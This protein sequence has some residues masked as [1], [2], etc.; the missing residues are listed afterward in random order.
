MLNDFHLYLIYLDF[1]FLFLFYIYWENDGMEKHWKNLNEGKKKT[2][3]I[4]AHWKL[5]KQIREWFFWGNLI[6]L[7]WN[8]KRKKIGH[9]IAS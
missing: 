6:K 9:K 5:I 7:D 3:K 8:C 2:L 1:S 4:N